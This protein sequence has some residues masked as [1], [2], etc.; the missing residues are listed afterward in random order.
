MNKSNTNM[1]LIAI[2][3]NTPPIVAPAIPI[4]SYK[5]II[6]YY[7]YHTNTKYQCLI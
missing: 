5:L 4:Y 1:G 7:I 3:H 2:A 6:L